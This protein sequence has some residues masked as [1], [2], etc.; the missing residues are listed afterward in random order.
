MIGRPGPSISISTPAAR[1]WSTSASVKRIRAGP[2][3]DDYGLPYTRN[4]RGLSEAQIRTRLRAALRATDLKTWPPNQWLR[5]RGGSDLVTA[6]DHTGGPA[7]WARELGLPL[8]DR[9]VHRPGKRWTPTTTAAALES[10]LAG[11]HTW[12]S[13]REFEAAGLAGLHATISK[14]DGHRTTAARYGLPLQRPRWRH[15]PSGRATRA[16]A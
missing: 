2:Y 13:R 9:H 6:I 16:G 15:T 1:A 12:P 10:L 14:H 8:H 3:A 4:A 7:R 11:R 5:T